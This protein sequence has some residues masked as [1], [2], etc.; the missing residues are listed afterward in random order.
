MLIE[1]KR[2]GGNRKIAKKFEA[3]LAKGLE[4]KL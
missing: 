2:K 1:K 3:N 4:Y